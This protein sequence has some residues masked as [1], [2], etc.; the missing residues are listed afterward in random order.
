MLDQAWEALQGLEWGSDLGPL[1]A[2]DQ[3]IDQ[4]SGNPAA[5]AEL[6]EKFVGLLGQVTHAG[7]DYICRRLVTLGSDRCVPALA[8]LLAN[9]DTAHQA[10][11]TLEQLSSPTAVAALRAAAEAA[12]GAVKIGLMGSLAKLGDTQATGLFV[13]AIKAE[14]QDVHAA[15]VWCLGQVGGSE[16]AEA[17]AALQPANEAGQM[18]IT[19][20]LLSCADRFLAAGNNSAARDIFRKFTSE[21]QP[22]HVRLAANKGVL[23]TVRR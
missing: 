4:A 9:S 6:E 10:R 11:L 19:E 18:A 15:A 16:A 5:Q 17:L 21:N 2:I 8:P 20:A 22:Q 7:R 12:T 13:A 3:A 1:T 14:E 23:A